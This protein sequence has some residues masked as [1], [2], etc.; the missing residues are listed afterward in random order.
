MNGALAQVVD[1]H[2][3]HD[4][5]QPYTTSE[6]TKALFQMASLKSPGPD[7]LVPKCK[8]PEVLSQFMPISLCNVVYKI[9]SKAIANRLKPI[10]D[11]II[12]P[13]QSSFVPGWL[14]SDN[15]LL[16]FELNHFLN[17][18]TQG[19]QGWMALKLDVSKAYDKVEWSFLEQV[20]SQS[21]Q[22]VKDM[23]EIYK[24]AS[25]GEQDGTLFGPPVAD[26]SL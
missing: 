4:L 20:S 26:S 18:K 16:A 25:E 24:S 6:V 1:A 17:N 9:A 11:K 22:A 8:H 3:G 19:R 12:S 14:I 15:I 10:L 7:V 23:L 5:L 13:S 21:S 2:M